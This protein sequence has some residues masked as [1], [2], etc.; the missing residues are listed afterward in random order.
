M[1]EGL[2]LVAIALYVAWRLCG[3][4]ERRTSNNRHEAD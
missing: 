1:A 3:L 2:L 4:I